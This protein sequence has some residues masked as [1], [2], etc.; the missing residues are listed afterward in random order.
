MES[1]NVEHIVIYATWLL[2]FR[3][4]SVLLSF[5]GQRER[6]REARL[7]ECGL[8]CT[9]VRI[10]LGHVR[11]REAQAEGCEQ[12]LHLSGRNAPSAVVRSSSFREGCFDR[13]IYTVTIAFSIG[14][15]LKRG[16]DLLDQGSHL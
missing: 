2:R 13:S 16:V 7:R 11:R 9:R 10:E 8:T 1:V 15:S 14:D 4:R 12:R 5:Q 3:L 6:R